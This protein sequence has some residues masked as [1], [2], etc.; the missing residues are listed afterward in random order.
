MENDH[1]WR[2]KPLDVER[3]TKPARY[4]DGGG[5]Y[6]IVTGADVKNW[7][8]RYWPQPLSPPLRRCGSFADT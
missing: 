7:S 5:F 2:I 6:L 1:G 4:A 3:E 8:F